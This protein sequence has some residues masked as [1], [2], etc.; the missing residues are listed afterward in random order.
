MLNYLIKATLVLVAVIHVA[1]FYYINDS[2]F[3]ILPK[4]DISFLNQFEVQYYFMTGPNVG[5]NVMTMKGRAIIFRDAQAAYMVS[6]SYRVIIGGSEK[7]FYWLNKANN[8]Q[9]TTNSI[10]QY[11]HSDYGP[12]DLKETND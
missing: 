8:W 4:N 5:K 12:F 9:S 2:D 1:F 6:E 7:R 10:S 11:T 3:S